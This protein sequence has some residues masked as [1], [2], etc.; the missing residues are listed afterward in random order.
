[1]TQT[2]GVTRFR[3]YQ[4]GS[5][6]SSFSYFAGGHFT[7]I[8]ARLTEQSRPSLVLEMKACGVASADLLHITSWD[9]DHCSASELP[10]LLALARPLKVELPG[11]APVSDT[12]KEAGKIIAAYI[13]EGRHDNRTKTA[14][15]VSPDYIS[16]LEHASRLAFKNTYYNPLIID[17]NCANNN[18]T[19]KHFRRGSF[20]VLSLGDV[21]SSIISA[22]LRRD[23][24]L[25]RETDI[26]I[27]AHHGADNGFTTKKFLHHIEPSLAICSADYS[28]QYDHP[29]QEI[30]DLLH[31][32]GIRLMTTKTGDVI[33]QST[34]DHTGTYQ[35]INLKAGSTEVSSR[36]S[37]VAR[38]KKLLTYNADTLRNIYA[39][40]PAYRRL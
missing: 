1:M 34:G 9:T 12:A 26:M 18:S 2:A 7:L 8:E 24:I 37:F 13:A 29:R 22:R 39:G 11:Y 20:N 14:I 35:A 30:R 16:G 3:A 31:D 33:V 36:C 27:L 25:S 23:M 4:L 17:P 28:N 19:V 15:Q 10:A 38:K 5:A 21:E 32:Q 40:K 6:G